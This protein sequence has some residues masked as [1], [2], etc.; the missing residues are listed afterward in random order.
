MIKAMVEKS[1]G[2][3]ACVVASVESPNATIFAK[4]KALFLVPRGTESMNQLI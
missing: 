1:E 4:S 3:K 2:R